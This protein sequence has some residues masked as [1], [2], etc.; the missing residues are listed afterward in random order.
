MAAF[1]STLRLTGALIEM[2]TSSFELI[3]QIR[4][5]AGCET[6]SQ[7]LLKGVK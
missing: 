6:L 2:K 1:G 3:C 5:G 7:T 4:R